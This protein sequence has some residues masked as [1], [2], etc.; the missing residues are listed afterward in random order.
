MNAD[1][2][3]SAFIPM[4]AFGI[5]GDTITAILVGVLLVKGI[6]PGPDLFLN[7]TDTLYAIYII[8][9]LSQL[10]LLLIGFGSIRLAPYV[11]RIPQSV[12]SVVIVAIATVGA[13]AINNGYLEVIIM[14]AMGVVG[15]A[16]ERAKI[17]LAPVVL[18]IVLGPIVER[19]F[20]SSVI[21]TNW[22]FTQFFSRPISAV[23]IVLVAVFLVISPVMNVIQ[24]RAEKRSLAAAKATEGA[25][26]PA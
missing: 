13:Y 2:L 8:F 9:I 10:V 3:G 26:E 7:Q 11:L 5:P 12:L 24:N 25:A 17:P 23:L 16:F 4:L 6:T 18:G 20:M 1:V 15:F 21:K 22:D 14:L 19:N